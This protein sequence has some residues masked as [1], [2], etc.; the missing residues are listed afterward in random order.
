M[1]A[2]GDCT[3]VY[4]ESVIRSYVR[5]ALTHCSSWPLVHC[6]LKRV[7]QMLVNNGYSN[8]DFDIISRDMISKHM[9]RDTTTAA[10]TQTQT[11]NDVTLYY[12]NTLT[13]AWKKDEKVIRDIV[14]KTIRPV[15]QN[16]RIR[17]VIYYKSPRTASLVMRN[18]S[19]KTT[20]MKQTDVVYRF[21]CTSGD[22]ATRNVYYIG[23]TTTSL[24]RRLTM[25]LQ[26]GGPKMHLWTQHKTRLTRQLL[27][28][29]T[30]IVMTCHDKRRLMAT[31]TILIRD[32]APIINA[33]TKTL[34]N[35]P[36]YDRLLRDPTDTNA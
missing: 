32:T 12:K 30:T 21:K 33:Q 7:R 28:D 6:E 24:S 5:R 29:N 13:P 36:L 19:T 11:I 35:L 15:N 17:L 26:E 18:D 10:R 3:E 9:D 22:C 34:T 1:N 8:T 4:K 31:E 16:D 2:R 14:T 25:H 23:H 27:T 20:T